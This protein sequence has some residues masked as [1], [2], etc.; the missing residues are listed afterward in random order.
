MIITFHRRN[1]ADPS[2]LHLGTVPFWQLAGKLEN[3][4]FFVSRSGNTSTEERNELQ[5]SSFEL[6]AS[7]PTGRSRLD[8][9][10][11][12]AALQDSIMARTIVTA[13]RGGRL[14]RFYAGYCD[15][16]FESPLAI[17]TLLPYWIGIEQWYCIKEGAGWLTAASMLRLFLSH[18]SRWLDGPTA[19]EERTL[20]TQD[21]RSFNSR[22]SSD[23]MPAI[24]ARKVEDLSKL[25]EHYLPWLEVYEIAAP[26]SRAWNVLVRRG[27]EDL[28]A[29]H[30]KDCKVHCPQTTLHVGRHEGPAPA[31]AGSWRE[32]CQLV[33]NEETGEWGDEG[34]VRYQSEGSE[35]DSEDGE[36]AD[37]L[38]TESEGSWSGG[39]ESGPKSW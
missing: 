21:V 20:T 10:H 22:Y 31:A 33:W 25:V 28:F 18:A 13:A 14:K 4:W 9:L 24:G 27:Q 26:V 29:C 34:H 19:R 6:P 3:L 38:N 2:V 36:A 1:K 17:P 15:S 35:A 23:R 5:V 39:Q 30:C 37:W 12:R 32:Q 16:E 7:L 8:V 11:E